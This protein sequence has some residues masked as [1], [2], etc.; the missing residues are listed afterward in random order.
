[1]ELATELDGELLSVDSMQVYRGMDIGTA[2]PTPEQR[3]AIPHHLIDIADPADDFSVAEF[4]TAGRRALDEVL[5]RGKTPV[6]VGGTGLHFRAIVDPLEFPPTD[7]EVRA[8]LE[9]EDQETLRRRLLVADPA[10]ASVVDLDNPR[11]VTRALEILELTGLTPFARTMSAAAAAVREYRPLVPFVG[12]GVDPGESLR[13]QIHDRFDGMLAAGLL[14][15]VESL[16][17]RLG[18][19]ARQAVGYKEMLEVIAG[20]ATVTEGRDA[21]IAATT[22]LAKRQRTF[23]RRDPRISWLDTEPGGAPLL[24]LAH[25]IIEQHEGS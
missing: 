14:A 21:A 23:F 15:E 11:R 2:K 19:V 9:A 18:R 25:A 1:M 4:Q 6:I 16:A 20:A 17:P 22:A 12:I 7:P 13:A 24:A 3:A 5:A 8:A 10:A